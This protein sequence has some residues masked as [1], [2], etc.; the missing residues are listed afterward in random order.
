MFAA[1][2]AH[3]YIANW[4][5]ATLLSK[6]R[7]TLLDEKRGA[8]GWIYRSTD[9]GTR[10]IA[11]E[12]ASVYLYADRPASRP[13]TFTMAEFY[14]SPRLHN[15]IDGHMIDVPLAIG[16]KYWI[17]SKKRLSFQWPEAR[18]QGLE[19]RQKL[20]D[21]CRSRPAARKVK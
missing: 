3:T 5:A 12:N 21:A 4:N 13:F 10:I 11:Y 18:R 7:G 16:A 20:E 19:E 8:Y 15:D 2:V 17:S 14:D 1:G 9:P 6:Q